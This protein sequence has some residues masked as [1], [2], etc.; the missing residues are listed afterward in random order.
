MVRLLP[1][2]HAHER[3]LFERER[4]FPI[5]HLVAIRRTLHERHPWIASSLYA[6]FVEAKRIARARL[7]YAGSLAAMLPWLQDE[8]EEIDAIFPSGDPFPY[9]IE[10]NR[11][12]LEA[13]VG[14]MVEQHFIPR[15]IRL[16]DLF[17]PLPGAQGT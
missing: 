14:Y 7:R 9:G 13:L 1:D 5:M 16:E 8:I 2:H 15:P 12:T 11:P 6:A 10:P 4:I 17:V 3:E